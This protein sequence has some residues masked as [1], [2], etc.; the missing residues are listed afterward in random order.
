MVIFIIQKLIFLLNKVQNTIYS[1]ILCRDQSMCFGKSSRKK[2]FSEI[3]N[4]VDSCY[5]FEE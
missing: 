3:H 1:I 4:T 5:T 2:G